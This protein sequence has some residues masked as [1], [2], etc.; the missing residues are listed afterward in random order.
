MKRGRKPLGTKLVDRVDASTLA[1]QRL[2]VILDQVAGTLS[3]EQACVAIGVKE[4]A[5][6]ELRASA[7]QAAASGLEP[8]R[9]GR[10]TKTNDIDDRVAAL[11]DEMTM[12]RIELQ[13]ARIR[14]EIAVTMPDLYRRKHGSKKN[15]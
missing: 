4:S 15:R 9:A 7:L 8:G 10:P 11:E 14:E 12:A 3:V 2:K 1:K 6:F 5:F 13:A